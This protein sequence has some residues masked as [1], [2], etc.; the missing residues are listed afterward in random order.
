LSCIGEARVRGPG[1]AAQQR[2]PREELR[3]RDRRGP[4]RGHPGARGAPAAALLCYGLPGE[5]EDAAN[6]VN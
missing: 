6:Q 1:F 5:P 2:V 3:A 4:E